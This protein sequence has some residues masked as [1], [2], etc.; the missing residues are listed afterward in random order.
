MYTLALHGV[1]GEDLVLTGLLLLFG[2]LHVLQLR[3][4]GGDV[5]QDKEGGIIGLT[6]QQVDT[7]IGQLNA[8]VLLVDHEIEHIGSLVHVLVVLRHVVF[9]GL[10]HLC[11]DT[12]LAE[13]F[14]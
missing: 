4:L 10:Q 1:V 13:V 5:G 6:R 9:L 12:L 7:L 3:Q 14:D 11:L 8:V 2:A